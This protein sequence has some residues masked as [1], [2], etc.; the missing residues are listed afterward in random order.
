MKLGIIGNWNNED[1]FKYAASLGITH[2]EFCM[3]V[4]TD[5]AKI[6]SEVDELKARL[7]RHGLACGAVGRWGEKRIDDDGNV[8]PEALQHDKNIIDVAAAIGA[9]VFN[10]GCNFAPGKNFSENCDIVTDYFKTLIEYA[11]PRG[12]K[13]AIYNCSWTNDVYD[14]RTWDIILPR[15]PELGIK[16]DTSHCIKRRGDYLKEMSKYGDRFYHFHLK[17][18]VFID[19]E[20]Y[21]DPPVGLDSTNWGAVMNVLYYVNYNGVLSLEPH[22]P[23]NWTGNKGLWG[24]EFSVKYITPYIMPEDYKPDFPGN[25]KP[26]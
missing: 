17:G 14:A 24:I 4:G 13:V 26:W 21:D 1:F 5:S 18:T 23:Q 9:P 10:T 19:G 7:E 22:S 11:K 25:F 16:Y 3:N 6:L 15:L 20:H 8:I 12:V 2:L